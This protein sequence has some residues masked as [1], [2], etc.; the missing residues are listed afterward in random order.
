MLNPSNDT[1]YAPKRTL[2]AAV[3]RPKTRDPGAESAETAP[4]L[5]AAEAAALAEELTLEAD[6]FALEAML[7][8]SHAA[9]DAASLAELA[10]P[11]AALLAVDDAPLT[12]L[13][14]LDVAEL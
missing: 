4:L 10:L 7:L 3:A 5:P 8:A 6:E 1:T 14:A 11:E 2:A 13:P 12:T 9:E